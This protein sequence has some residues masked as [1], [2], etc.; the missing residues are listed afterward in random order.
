MV[1]ISE[2]WKATLLFLLGAVP[3]VWGLYGP[4]DSVILL[5][6][7]SFD[8][9][10]VKSRAVSVV[11]FFAPWCGHCKTLAPQYKKLAENVKG[12]VNVFAVDCES[13]DGKALCASQG[14]RAFP[15]IKLFGHERTK[16]PYTGEAIKDAVD[17][18]GARTAKGIKE[19][20]YAILADTYIKKPKSSE[21]YEQ[22]LT[23]APV[24]PLAVVFSDKGE[25]SDL[26]KGLASKLSGRMK[27]VQIGPKLGDLLERYGVSSYP[28]LIILK[29]DGTRV[30][31]EGELRGGALYGFLDSLAPPA[32]P[33]LEEEKPQEKDKGQGSPSEGD[34]KLPSPPPA[35]LLT[36]QQLTDIDKDPD[37]WLIAFYLGAPDECQ[38]TEETLQRVVGEMQGV[39]RVGLINLQQPSEE[40]LPKGIP[41]DS[42][43]L[44]TPG[45]VPQLVLFPEGEDKA[46]QEDYQVYGGELDGKALQK[47]VLDALPDISHEISPGPTMN[48]FMARADET[49]ALPGPKVVLFSSKGE[50]P[51]VFKALALNLRGK[52][53]FN[54]GWFASNDPDLAEAKKMFKVKKTPS[55][56]VT[57]FVPLN[58]IPESQRPKIVDGNLPLSIQPYPGP[59]KYSAMYTWL[60]QFAMM[61]GASKEEVP[62]EWKAPAQRPLVAEVSSQTQWQEACLDQGGLCVVA[63]LDESSEGYKEEVELFKDVAA[64]HG[65]E[66]LHFLV[67]PSA[68]QPRLL[69]AV[70]ITAPSQQ[71][72]TAVVV[73]P[74]K[75][76]Y[77]PLSR[78]FDRQGLVD[79]VEGVLRG[80]SQ[81]K[82][83]EGPL[84][85]VDGG[86][87]H[88]ATIVPEGSSEEL[89]E[90]EFDL[91]D[92]LSEDVSAGPIRK[93]ELLKQAEEILAK[94]AAEAEAATKTEVKKKKKKSKS[95]AKKKSDSSKDE[96]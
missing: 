80:K 63:L 86:E 34:Q 3:L 1:K 30:P 78:A 55:M 72:P 32:G 61:I 69:Q 49:S 65:T 13:A 67:V 45:C 38:S 4:E 19:A 75:Q 76:M 73:S 35:E 27:F 89:V 11:E 81:P 41:V 36:V 44:F 33:E 14:I 9:L 77:I 15:T 84:E 42:A 23:E 6:K 93:E 70:D 31:Y 16:N 46:D 95:K 48:Q 21:E 8:Q 51:G 18:T 50:V 39:V 47:W 82:S 87:D 74:K 96:L 54:F 52:T 59:L 79:L 91:S 12:I 92:I 5:D 62:D 37:V 57:F 88:D 26:F 20:A 94:E 40:E 64:N 53:R 25:P 56:V 29:E 71:L 24:L 90:E 68:R 58:Q 85:Y 28:T 17:Y 22:I 10:V 83:L 7:N 43:A 66:A 2:V 60:R